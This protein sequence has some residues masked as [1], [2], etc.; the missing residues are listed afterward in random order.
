MN[1]PGP[2]TCLALN[3]EEAH[4][5]A[6]AAAGYAA[7]LPPER[8]APYR[9]LADSA[10]TGQIPADLAGVLEQ[11]AA[12]SLQSGQAR[13]AGRA[14]AE[15]L[16]T[17]VYRRTPAGQEAAAQVEAVNRALGALLGR[18]LDS[19]RVTSPSPGQHTLSLGVRGGI[20]V[21]LTVSLAGVTVTSVQ[22]G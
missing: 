14:E 9:A 12:V 4:A 1:A 10:A 5:V 22:A 6:A 2:G 18:E 19:A 16:L 8:A 13:K 7:A 21:T 15:R 3:P 11:V 20:T 17:A